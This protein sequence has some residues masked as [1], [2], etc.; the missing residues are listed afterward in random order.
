MIKPEQLAKELGL[1]A[2]AFK[3][4][5]DAPPASRRVAESEQEGDRLGLTGT[6]TF[7]VNGRRLQIQGD[8]GSTLRTEIRRELGE[9]S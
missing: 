3:R 8:I 7:F 4:C 1:D 6:P 5:Y 9:S 2:E